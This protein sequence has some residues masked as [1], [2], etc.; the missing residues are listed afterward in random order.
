MLK[1]PLHN[2]HIELGAKM[3]Q[4]A[5][6]E[7]PLWYPTKIL[8]EH[9]HTRNSASLFDIS[10]M[11]QATVSGSNSTAELEALMPTDLVSLPANRMRYTCFT[12]EQGGILD[13]LIVSNLDSEFFLVINAARKEHDVKHLRNNLSDSSIVEH[14]ADALVALQGPAASDVLR[15]WNAEISELEFMSI[16]KFNIKGVPCIVS[17]SG[18]TG[19]DGFEISV[20]A[21]SVVDFAQELLNEPE[22]MPAGLGARDSLRLEAGLRLY[23]QDMDTETTPVE[24]GIQWTI[25]K[26]RRTN[27]EREGGFPGSDVILEQ[28]NHGVSRKIAGMVLQGNAPA[29][30]GVEVALD[31]GETIGNVTS[32]T[33]APTVGS[34]IAMGY[35]DSA[36]TAPGSQVNLMLRGK[37]KPATIVK[38]PFVQHQYHKPAT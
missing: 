5:G 28:L 19:E 12:N 2:L 29:R 13:D 1:S 37:P 15:R 7:M 26:S 18:Y 21:E 6:Y 16:S 10:H 24:A 27:G 20:P 23:G 11:G 34:P 22:V 32:G 17:R 9:H 25:P 35:V 8:A 38:L 4:F 30:T 31:G 14:T 3:G 36:H 33:F